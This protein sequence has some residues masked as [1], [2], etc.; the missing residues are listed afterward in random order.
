MAI[1]ITN[2]KVD[3]I[4]TSNMEAQLVAQDGLTIAVGGLISDESTTIEKR[5]PGLHQLPWLGV[6]SGSSKT[7]T[8]RT[9]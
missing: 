7:T 9:S 3:S 4:R 2:F 5:I 8:R 1:G 6:F